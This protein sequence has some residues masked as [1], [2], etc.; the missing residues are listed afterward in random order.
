MEILIDTQVLI[1]FQVNHPNLGKTAVR[2]ITDPNNTIYVSDISLYEIAIK[3]TIGKLA[4]FNVDIRDIVTVGKEDGF[5][6]IPL[7][8]DAIAAYVNIPLHDG[9]RDPFDRLIIATAKMSGLTLLSADEKFELYE[10][11]VSLIKL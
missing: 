6:F 4:D 3:Q 5:N 2:L 8:H 11:Y 7:N 1:W 9:H 10:D